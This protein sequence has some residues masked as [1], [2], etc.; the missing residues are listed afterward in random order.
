MRI[1]APSSSG[2]SKISRGEG[3]SNGMASLRRRGF[4]RARSLAIKAFQRPSYGE[5]QYTGQRLIPGGNQGFVSDVSSVIPREA[6][7][8]SQRLGMRVVRKE[9]PALLSGHG[10]YADDLAVPAGTLHAHVIRSPHPHAHIVSIDTRAALEK[11]GVW[12]VIT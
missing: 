10:R 3:S 7:R 11:D 9:D 2:T 8:V 6:S 12:A 4:L 1:R 5:H